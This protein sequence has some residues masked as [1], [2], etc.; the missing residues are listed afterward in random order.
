M[1]FFSSPDR[2]SPGRESDRPESSDDQ[3]TPR[4]MT[5]DFLQLHSAAKPGLPSSY[6]P[7][8]AAA[9]VCSQSAAFRL[10]LQSVDTSSNCC[11]EIQW[12]SVGSKSVRLW[13]VR[14]GGA[15][16]RGNKHINRITSCS[17]DCSSLL[18]RW[19]FCHTSE[20][21][22][23]VQAFCVVRCAIVLVLVLRFSASSTECRYRHGE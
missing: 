1:N 2:A 8:A 5:E 4:R 9:A 23:K 6:C 3:S 16:A 22:S 21:S 18:C 14:R 19:A 12:P 7:A 15:R 11:D 20:P 17:S 13:K 10:G